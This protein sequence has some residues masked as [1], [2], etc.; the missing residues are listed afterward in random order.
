V[1]RVSLNRLPVA[2]VIGL[3]ICGGAAAE[4]IHSGLGEIVV[5][6]TK[7]DANLHDIAQAITALT[8]DDLEKRGIDDLLSLQSQVPN[9]YVGQQLG[10]ARI[11]LRGIG[12]ENIGPASE[13]SIAVHGDGMYLSRPSA[14]LATFFDVERVEILRG[15]QG[16]LYGR[17][18]TGGSVNVISRRPTAKTTGHLSLAVGNFDSVVAEGALGG[19][20]V[21]DKLL[22]RIAVQAVE[23]G[24]F[25]H[26][27]VTGHEIDNVSTLALRGHL[28]FFPIEHV[29][30]LLRAEYAEASDRNHGYHF[31]SAFADDEGNLIPPLG[32]Q[33]GGEFAADPRDIANEVDPRND[34][35]NLALSLEAEVD[36][37]TFRFNSLTAYLDSALLI[38]S[39]LD[40]SS[41]P[42]SPLYLSEDAVQ[43]SQ[44]LRLTRDGER[45][46]WL[47]GAYLFDE[48]MDGYFDVA[49]S[50]GLFG[51]TPAFL[52][53]GYFAGGRIETRAYALFGEV[54]REL[55]AKSKLTLGAR[56]SYEEK[57]GDE[58]VRFDLVTPNVP[59]PGE[60]KPPVLAT[61]R[62]HFS[63]FTPKLEFEREFGESHLAYASA[64]RGFKS[65]AINLG[66]LQSPVNPEQVW[67]YEIGLKADSFE[68][69]S[70]AHVAGFY[71][72]YADLQV[73]QVRNSVLVLENAASATIF[74][75]E[76]EISAVLTEQLRLD[77]SASWLHA[78]YDDFITQDQARPGQGNVLDP[79]TGEPAFQL[80]GNQLT[81]APEYSVNVGGQYGWTTRIGEFV[82]RGE[83][84]WVDDIY[85][86]PFNLQST[87]Q[88]AHSR[89]NLFLNW[90]APANMTGGRWSGQLF[91]RNLDDGEDFSNV[92]V[93]SSIVGN[94][95]I[96]GYQQP[97]TFG[98]SLGYEF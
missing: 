26:N 76:A 45:W 1:R 29:S 12:L 34:R 43:V 96:G 13:G 69:R 48:T 32:P 49:L 80:A 71:Y 18:A 38:R 55:G 30:M 70:R 25:G 22:G 2:P 3:I 54:A 52:T 56:F 16:T 59:A 21:D 92:F 37:G 95:V 64:S 83:V 39:D 84:N 91:V 14:A 33:F 47:V 81:Q 23:R 85:F 60:V 15:P 86:T 9:F 75:A 20:L 89:Q 98:A 79:V 7:R 87:V 66:G 94:P 74:G 4:D 24:G 67:A 97:R 35:A 19:P 44:E 90:S 8:G 58:R 93:A 57:R 63:A 72:D 62:E 42:L 61:P 77:F 40:N 28:Q 6:A 11:S 5:T 53:D 50:S 88:R 46:N 41:A 73:G 68:Q 36:W 31:I 27:V 51:V 82:L 78:E 10:G 65:G 17:N